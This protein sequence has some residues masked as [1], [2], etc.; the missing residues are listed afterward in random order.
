MC[1]VKLLSRAC[2]QVIGTASA[3]YSGE[4]KRQAAEDAV[5]AL[6]LDPNGLFRQN[7]PG[8]ATVRAVEHTG[9]TAKPGDAAAPAETGLPTAAA[10]AVVPSCRP[11][12]VPWGLSRQDAAYLHFFREV[13]TLARKQS[14]WAAVSFC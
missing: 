8:E 13:S 10:G 1:C 11:R 3:K 4:A 7:S 9:V 6:C 14:P 5:L 2:W 12:A